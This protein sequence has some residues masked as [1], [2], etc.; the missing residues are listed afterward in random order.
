[1][2][3]ESTK[4]L[5]I[6]RKTIWLVRMINQAWSV[7]HCKDTIINRM[8]MTKDR[9]WTPLGLRLWTASGRCKGHRSRNK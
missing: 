1:M 7:G 9:Q 8:L 5:V 6:V 2:E 3:Q 4:D